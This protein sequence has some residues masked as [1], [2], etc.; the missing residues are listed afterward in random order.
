VSCALC[1]D[2]AVSIGINA[3]SE[4]RGILRV[5]RANLGDNT[6]REISSGTDLDQ[7][8]FSEYAESDTWEDYISYQFEC[9]SCAQKFSL[10]AETYHGGGGKWEPC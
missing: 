6:I 3:P 7:R 1:Q 8:P 9:C 10:T 4:L 2:L 5:V